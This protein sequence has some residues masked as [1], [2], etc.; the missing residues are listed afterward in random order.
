MYVRPLG[1][2]LHVEVFVLGHSVVDLLGR[3][4]FDIRSAPMSHPAM[5]CMSTDRKEGE[6]G[7]REDGVTR[8]CL[9]I[10]IRG[11]ERVTCMTFLHPLAFFKERELWRSALSL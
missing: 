11:G 9:R 10:E 1:G 4:S 5:N 2:E 3:W 8:E 7:V 6:Q